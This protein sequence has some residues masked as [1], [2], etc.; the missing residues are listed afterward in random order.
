MTVYIERKNKRLVYIEEKSTS[1][2]WDKEWDR[3][4]FKESILK[5]KDNLFLKILMKYIPNKKGRILEGGC[6]IGGKVYCMQKYGYRAI[7]VDY[8]K[9]T[10]KR[11]KEFMPQL[12][13]RIGDI[14]NLPFPDDYFISYISLGV[15]EHFWEGY[16]EILK[17]MKRVLVNRG[18][19]ILS[20]PYTSPLRRLKMRLGLYDYKEITNKER[21]KFYQFALNEK[22]VI[23]DF[24]KA[25]FK[26]LEKQPN[27]GIKGFKEEIF[28]FKR[29][30]KFIM[31]KVYDYQGKNVWL[32]GFK[33]F[34]EKLLIK[35][36][37]GHM[38]FLVFRKLENKI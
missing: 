37:A 32:I 2:F 34:L 6:G 18:Y 27:Y 14:R 11:V 10:I 4:D 1:D 12:D 3:K 19:L 38:I 26:F 21:E 17:E 29:I 24:E 33:Y 28:I 13:V 31:Q 25:G 8:A 22:N 30:L 35:F 16:I 36:G 23:R 7:G 20:F 5:E 15:I 9:K